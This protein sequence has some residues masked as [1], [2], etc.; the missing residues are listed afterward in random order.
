ME[1]EVAISFRERQDYQW[2][3]Q[4]INLLMKPLTQNLPSLQDV[5]G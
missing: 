4:D 2:V 5:Q 1:P 3:Q